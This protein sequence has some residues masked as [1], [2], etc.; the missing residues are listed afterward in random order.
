MRLTACLDL[1]SGSSSSSLQT[2]RQSVTEQKPLSVI[3]RLCAGV[4][5]TFFN[6]LAPN[7]LVVN[8]FWL[9]S[10]AFGRIDHF[11]WKGFQ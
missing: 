7:Y 4:L 8:S 5:K 11:T 9:F 6:M 10:A 1:L 3:Q 2:N